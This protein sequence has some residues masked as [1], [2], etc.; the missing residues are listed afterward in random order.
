MLSTADDLRRRLF[1][2]SLVSHQQVY[3]RGG[4]VGEGMT[5]YLMFVKPEATTPS[6][7][8]VRTAVT[9]FLNTGAFRGTSP[10]SRHWRELCHDIRTGG[11]PELVDTVAAD[12]PAPSWRG[13]VRRLSPIA[14]YIEAI[15]TGSMAQ[16]V[17][18][19]E[20]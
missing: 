7:T 17:P 13:I 14:K 20:F 5:M 18:M 4:T 16:C 19:L 9:S 3:G 6:G 12:S 10:E 2:F 8:K 1:M 15:M 11:A